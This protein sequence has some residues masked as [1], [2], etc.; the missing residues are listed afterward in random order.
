MT[1]WIRFEHQSHIGF[2]VLEGERI[3]VHAGDMFNEPAATTEVLELDAV[4]ILAPCAPAKMIGLANNS[5]S[6]AKKYNIPNLDYPHFFIKPS[7]TFVPCGGTIL[8]PGEH[9]K[10]IFY[11][12][13]LGIVIGKDGRQVDEEE[14]DRCIFGYTCVNDVT[15]FQLSDENPNF[16]QWTRAKAFDT[17]APFGPAICTDIALDQVSIR[18]VL[19]GRERQNYSVSDLIY[20]PR[21]IVSMLSAE[22]TLFPGDLIACG[23]GPGALPMRSG[24]TIDIEIDGIGKLSNIFQ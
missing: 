13:E 11:E 23:T 6:L 2:G 15:A 12:A 14:A 21:Q 4:D 22:M 9:A 7:N 20:S 5:R 3:A 8:N 17:F 16:P 1:R 10:R 18:A 19:N 24:S